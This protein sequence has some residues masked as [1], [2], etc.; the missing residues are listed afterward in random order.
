MPRPSELLRGM[1]LE[2]LAGK[3][4]DSLRELGRWLDKLDGQ[5]DPVTQ[6]INSGSG[7]PANASYVTLS[8]TPDLSRERMLAAADPITLTDGGANGSV[9][10]GIDADAFDGRYLKLDATNDPVTGPL[11]IQVDD[12]HALRVLSDTI[13]VTDAGELWLFEAGGVYYTDNYAAVSPV[14]HKVAGAM[15]DVATLS[16]GFISKDG[17]TV[18]LV[19]SQTANKGIYKC[20]N[21]KAA[22]P[23]WTEILT[24][25][26]SG[27]YPYYLAGGNWDCGIIGNTLWVFAIAAGEDLFYGYHQGEYNGSTWVWSAASW[28][29]DDYRLSYSSYNGK[30]RYVSTSDTATYEVSTQGLIST[31]TG[32][33]CAQDQRWQM[34]DFSAALT[35]M[36]VKTN[37]GTK[38]YL[39][40]PRTDTVLTEITGT[41]A[42][43]NAGGLVNGSVEGNRIF[44][45]NTGASRGDIY[46]GDTTGVTLKANWTYAQRVHDVKLAG[47]GALIATVSQCAASGEVARIST[48]G[49]DTWTDITG[50]FWTLTTG[51]KTFYNSGM[52]YTVGNVTTVFNVDTLSEDTDVVRLIASDTVQ[53]SRLI[54]TV[55]PG[56][57]PLTVAST[58]LNTNLNADLLDGLHAS[59]FATAARKINTTAPLTGGG[60]LSADRTLAITQAGAAADGYLS[61]TDWNTFNNKQP[62]GN[63]ITALTGDVTATGPGSAAAAL[64]TVNSNVG[65]FTYASVTVN[66]KGLV[67]AASSGATPITG[68]PGT[69]TSAT[70]NV[71]TD[72]HT[73][74]I[75]GA[76]W[77]ALANTFTLGPQTV[78]TGADA[79][80]GIIAK[81]NSG[82][83]TGNLF[84]V[85]NSGGTGLSAFSG[86]GNLRVG[87]ATVRD[88]A[89][90]EVTRTFTSTALDPTL[91]YYYGIRTTAAA[92]PTGNTVSNWRVYGLDL[93]AQANNGN[94]INGQIYAAQ[95]AGQ[96]NMTGGTLTSLYG[97]LFAANGINASGTTTTTNVFVGRFQLGKSGAGTWTIGTAS[98]ALIA[99]PSVSAGTLNGT[100]LYGLNIEDM[101]GANSGTW[102]NRYAVNSAGGR[103]ALANT[104]DETLLSLTGFATQSAATSLVTLTRNDALTNA[105]GTIQTLVQN[106]TGTAAAGF[107]ARQLWQ[108]ESSTTASQDAGAIDVYW[109][110][111]STPDG[112]HTF[113]G[114]TSTLD[115]KTVDNA[116]AL[117]TRLSIYGALTRIGDASNYTQFA[118]DGT[119]SLVGT[120]KYERHVQVQATPSG[121]PASQMDS[122][123][124]GTATGLRASSTIDQYAGFQWEI[125]DDWDGTDAYV[126]IDWFPDSGAISGTD[127]VR[128]VIEY[129]AIAEGELITAGTVAT[130]D[131]G[132]GG[133]TGDYSQYQTKHT[134]M[135]LTY[136][137]ANQP[138]AVQDHLYFL[139]H[140]DTSVANDF[141]G[142]VVIPAFEIIYN[143]T[144]F[145]TSN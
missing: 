70:T 97:G 54:S 69:L 51:G 102:T 21:P 4:A 128:W 86:A 133:D 10:V 109:G 94:N 132:A 27:I 113:A 3:R 93:T 105:V 78:Q 33:H 95:F 30:S 68:T 139:V 141:S 42:G 96:V 71:A 114:R 99:K 47:G 131:N 56:T 90:L 62:A 1:M 119:L 123:T 108:L 89:G 18:Y 5:T 59:V 85:Q 15:P 101:N 57:A 13:A 37:D 77:L 58:T 41:Y 63:Y 65:T 9:T 134:R 110:R 45:I 2:A 107:G 118:A 104:A 39:Y 67:T 140:R 142:T 130:I 122:V 50:N 14:W 49:G 144:G 8:N 53:G 135:T 137:N 91:S 25:Q 11:D 7:A 92:S 88:G 100:T 16:R 125:P 74:A 46:V 60:D 120:A 111:N 84:E 112:A 32:Y 72:P 75:T 73:H 79:N 48:D 35:A 83:Q 24:G 44:V 126:E 12:E 23:I 43:F 34:W 81:A 116:G 117:T 115:L 127:A 38:T 124:I 76:A 87:S 52:T 22:T 36:L 31:P 103:W 6:V 55:A 143:S 64:A 98:L 82:T 20:S 66:A 121:T 136:N 26:S 61:S 17:S 80:K 28:N 29:S 19:Y 106:S 145:P 129:R 138:L 40:L